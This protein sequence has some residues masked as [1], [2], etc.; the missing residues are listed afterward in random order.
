M[1]I[2]GSIRTPKSTVIIKGCGQTLIKIIGKAQEHFC[3]QRQTCA[4]GSVLKGSQWGIW[5]V[6]K[7]S[8]SILCAQ[9][10]SGSVGCAN[11]EIL[12][13]IEQHAC[14]ISPTGYSGGIYCNMASVAFKIGKRAV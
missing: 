10:Y 6:F 7:S 9:V 14:N 2:Q 12:G 8:I 11:M 1:N 5:N 4:K 3:G 13:R